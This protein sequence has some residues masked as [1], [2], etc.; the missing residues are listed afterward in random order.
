[1]NDLEFIDRAFA[2]RAKPQRVRDMTRPAE[3]MYSDADA[4][5][6]M[7]WREFRCSIL[8]E[9]FDAIYGF[10]P[11]AFC[12]F[13]PGIYSAGIRENRPDL[14]VNHGLVTTLDRGNA[15]GSW[16]AFFTKR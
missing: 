14:L 8:D 9:Y 7:D 6:G 2:D 5:A 3:D 1:M 16:D 15:A 13:L 4:F 12:Y 11:E 10:S